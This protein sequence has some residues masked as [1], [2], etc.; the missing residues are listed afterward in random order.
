VIFDPKLFFLILAIVSLS[1]FAES[2][3][4]CLKLFGSKNTVEDILSKA[5]FDPKIYRPLSCAGNSARLLEKLTQIEDISSYQVLIILYEKGY[6]SGIPSR[7]KLMPAVVRSGP[8]IWNYHVVLFHQGQIMD[9]NSSPYAVPIK[10]YFERNFPKTLVPNRWD[11][12]IMKTVNAQDYLSEYLGINETY[13]P[14]Q[15]DQELAK[16]FLRNP[17]DQSSTEFSLSQFLNSGP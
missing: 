10:D 7:L 4:A 8:N 6:S 5:F 15:R 9:L 16:F 2:Q 11:N 14:D 13:S 1:L 12:L 3:Q 17:Q